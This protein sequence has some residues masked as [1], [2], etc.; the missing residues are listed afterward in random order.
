MSDKSLQQAAVD[1]ALKVERSDYFGPWP[2]TFITLAALWSLYQLWIASPIPYALGW[3]IFVDLP[4]RGIHL[5]FGLFLCFLLFPAKF[6]E[7]R[8]GKA[9][10]S[11]ILAII[12]AASALYVYLGYDGIV[13]RAGILANIDIL[14]FSIP[15]EVILSAVGMLLLL[16]ATRRGI[17]TP[18]VIVCGVFMVY[19]LFGPY[20]PEI[21]SHRGVSI[22]RMVGYNWL[23]SEAIFGI[24]IAVSLSYVFLFV[25]FGAFMDTAGAGKFFLDMSFAA[26]GKYRGGPAKAAIL[27]SGLTG[28]ISGS[29]IANTVTTGAFTIPV[30]KKTGFPGDKAGAIEVSASINGQLMPPIMGASAFIIAEFIGISYYDVIVHA[31]IPA[32]IAYISLFYISHL[33]SLKMGLVGLPKADLPA[34]TKTFKEGAYFLVPIGMLVYLLLVKRWSPG[35]AVFWSIMMMAGIIM[36]QQVMLARQHGLSVLKGLRSGGIIVFYSLVA[37]AKSMT[38]VTAAVGAAGIIVGIVS[39]TGL[40]NAMLGIVEA[41]SQ[42]NIYILL[43][44]VAVVSIIL[45]M[46]L[47]TTAN[48]IVVASLMAGVMVELGNASGL[49]LPLIAVHLYVFYFGLMADATPPVCLAAFAAS[50][51]SGADPM[52]TGIQSFKYAIRTAILPIVFIFNPELLLVGVDSIWQGGLIFVVALMAIFAFSSLTLQW[53]FVRLKLIESVFLVFVVISLFRPDFVLDRFSPAYEDVQM[54]QV[55]AGETSVG[56]GQKV[57]LYVTRE[58]EYGDRFKLFTATVPN[59]SDNLLEAVGI[60]VEVES[61]GRTVVSD[62]GFNGPAEQLG[63]TWGDYVT[64]V[65]LE[66]SGRMPKEIIYIF[67]ILAYAAVVLMQRRRMKKNQQADLVEA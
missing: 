19:S 17:G 26:V 5:A 50:A 56:E 2:K 44:L 11:L 38:A 31:M 27:A 10:F 62:I 42:G 36:L 29:S 24:P 48:Y 9:W 21:I 30:M 45:G 35:S 54:A 18:L 33:E 1:E 25:L 43:F 60:S 53:M 51:I 63:V 34:M 32:F 22:P 58:T 20:M 13:L 52:K 7:K 8:E 65:G 49:V 64:S 61:D 39:S 57:R 16:E 12:A 3:G 37:G 14:G 55:V 40:N 4:A 23:T 67:G 66:Q 47:P 59:A 28:M 6:E 15:Y 41:L 46:G